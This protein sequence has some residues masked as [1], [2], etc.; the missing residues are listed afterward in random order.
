MDNDDHG[1]DL[2]EDVLRQALHDGRFGL[3][4]ISNVTGDGSGQV[5]D[6]AGT[7]GSGDNTVPAL[8]VS[9][10]LL[11]VHVDNIASEADGD[12]SDGGGEIGQDQVVMMDVVIGVIVQIHDRATDSDNDQ[13]DSSKSTKDGHDGDLL[14]CLHGD[15]RNSHDGSADPDPCLGAEVSTGDQ[16]LHFCAGQDQVHDGGTQDDGSVEEP[17]SD[18]TGFAKG[19]ATNFLVRG[20]TVFAIVVEALHKQ[21]SS[22]DGHEQ[23]E[24]QDSNTDPSTQLESVGQTEGSGT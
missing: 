19:V 9:H 24:Q 16:S 20:E 4:T 21:D 18:Q 1:A 14:Q 10:G 22:V 6:R 12:G 17:N 2:G 7:Q 23:R 11:D 13:D 8:G 5:K 15:K 3:V